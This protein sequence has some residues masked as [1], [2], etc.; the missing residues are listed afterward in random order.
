MWQSFLSIAFAMASYLSR[1]QINAGLFTL[2]GGEG[3]T[4]PTTGPLRVVGLS[5]RVSGMLVMLGIT[6]GSGRS[7]SPSSRR[8]SR[9]TRG[10]R[11]S[12]STGTTRRRTTR[13]VP[14]ASSLPETAE[15]SSLKIVSDAS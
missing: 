10:G 13:Q 9:T 2:E 5:L 4:T 11:T 15:V 7:L 8:G 14:D 6:L 1:I 12:G 3:S